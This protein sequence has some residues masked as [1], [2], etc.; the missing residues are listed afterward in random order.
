[1][2]AAAST[3]ML[4]AAT[5]QAQLVVNGN[6]MNTDS[7]PLPYLVPMAA[8]PGVGWYNPYAGGSGSGTVYIV[9]GTDESG[10]SAADL[11]HITGGADAYLEQSIQGLVEGTTYQLSFWANES[12]PGL[13]LYVNLLMEP[14]SSEAS[15]VGV[16][17]GV[18]TEFTYNYKYA[19]PSTTSPI[20]FS[21]DNGTYD[22]ADVSLTVVPEPS[23]W[24][25]GVLLLLPMGMS[26]LR[27]LRQRQAA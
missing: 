22:I 25:A 4:A 26:T 15:F 7:K 11:A 12:A 18:W 17:Y 3:C 10:N 24:A 8:D 9:S 14:N 16:S 21:A 20:Y 6:F 13:S 1:M 2:L 27:L 23:T 5:L 19:S